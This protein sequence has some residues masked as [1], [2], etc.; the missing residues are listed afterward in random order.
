MNHKK[1]KSAQNDSNPKKGNLTDRDII[2]N[3]NF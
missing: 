1:Y 2:E 3:S